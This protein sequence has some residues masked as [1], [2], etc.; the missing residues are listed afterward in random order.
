M[1][2]IVVYSSKTGNTEKVAKAIQKGI[3]NSECVNISEV[4]DL[5]ADLLVIGGW[6]DKGTFNAETLEFIKNIKNR[7]VA[8]FFTLGAKVES[9]HGKDCA[10]KITALLKENSNEV[11]GSFYCQGAIDPKLIEFMSKLPADHIM[12]PNPE[13]VQN[14][15]DASTH[16]DE[17]DLEAATNFGKTL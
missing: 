6:I 5:S 4:K 3:A 16:P 12:A 11:V 14:W 9:D 17:K 10:E 8:F 15:K 2:T 7:K 13:R 1:K